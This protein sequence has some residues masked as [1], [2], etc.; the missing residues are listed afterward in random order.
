MSVGQGRE[1]ATTH[2]LHNYGALRAGYFCTLKE[3]GAM[4][5]VICP[6]CGVCEE[7]EFVIDRPSLIARPRLNPAHVARKREAREAREVGIPAGVQLERWAHL[8]GCGRWFNVA[9]DSR[10][11]K[12][13]HTYPVGLPPA[14]PADP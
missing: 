5:Q 3:H 9:R 12:I 13:L 10:T 7:H 1:E 2:V 8:H 11:K 6:Y 4:L 14:D